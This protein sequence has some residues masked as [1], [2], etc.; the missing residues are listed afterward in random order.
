M[1]KIDI[2][3]TELVKDTHVSCQVLETHRFSV[4]RTTQKQVSLKPTFETKFVN[5]EIVGSFWQFGRLEFLP[6]PSSLG[7]KWLLL[8]GVN[9]TSLRVK[10]WH[11]LD[12]AGS[13][14]K[15]R[16]AS[17]KPISNHPEKPT[18]SAFS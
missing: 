14:G 6:G 8:K 10:H 11:P 2:L 16:G 15:V 5:M 18:G 7:A 1:T 3:V 17:R 9:S 4:E 12:G 13:G